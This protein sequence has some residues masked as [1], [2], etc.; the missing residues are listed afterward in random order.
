MGRLAGTK[1]PFWAGFVGKNDKD[2]FDEAS[3]MRYKPAKRLPFVWRWKS[4]AGQ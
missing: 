3:A 2:L 4:L 1:E